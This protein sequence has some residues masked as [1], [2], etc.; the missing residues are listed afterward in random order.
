[1][2]KVK[3]IVII[4]L[5]VLFISVSEGKERAL[6]IDSTSSQVF[7]PL[8]SFLE[9]GERWEWIEISPALQGA[10]GLDFSELQEKCDFL[11]RG[12]ERDDLLFFEVVDL[13]TS[14]KIL[15][16]VRKKKTRIIC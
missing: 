11:F 8:R 2:K 12:Y 9:R 5:M 7:T 16:L 14:S 15:A 10:E 6:F 4:V 3:I 1:M 13:K